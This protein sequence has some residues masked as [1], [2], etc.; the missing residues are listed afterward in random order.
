MFARYNGVAFEL[1]KRMSNH[2]Q[3]N[4]GLTLS[5]STGRQGSSSARSTPLSSQI[6]TAG[7][8]GQNPNDFINSDG[9]LVGDRPV[10]LKT[11]FIYQLPWG[12]TSSFNFQSQSGKPIYSEI[13]ASPAASRGIPGTNRI[14][15]QR[16]STAKTAHQATGRRSTPASRRRSSSAA[17]RK[18]AVFGD[19]LNLFN[20]DANESVLDRRLGNVELPRAVALHPAAAADDRR[21]VPVLAGRRSGSESFRPAPTN[22]PTFRPARGLLP[23]RAAPGSDLYGEIAIALRWPRAPPRG[24]LRRAAS[25]R[26]GRWP[27]APPPACRARA[28]RGH[29]WP[30]RPRSPA[31]APVPRQ[32][33]ANCALGGQQA[34]QVVCEADI[35][36]CAGQRRFEA[37]RAPRASVP[38]R[39][40]RPAERVRH[41]RIVDAQPRSPLAAP[42]SP[43]RCGRDWRAPSRAR[44]ASACAAGRARWPG[45]SAPRPPRSRRP[46]GQSL[47]SRSKRAASSRSRLAFAVRVSRLQ[48]EHLPIARG[49]LLGPARG[50]QRRSE[51]VE[52]RR[53]SPGRARRRGSRA[54]PN[55]TTAR[56]V[57][58]RHRDRRGSIASRRRLPHDP[59]AA[60]ARRR[61]VRRRARHGNARGRHP[62]D[63]YSDRR[64]PEGRSA[65]VPTAGASSAR[66]AA[67]GRREPRPAMAPLPRRPR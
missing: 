2:W 33:L 23:I 21:E 43:R 5:K 11:Q 40:S 25:G 28:D 47:P 60:R 62:A 54:T 8:F 36:G 53:R 1:K 19:F 30:R 38:T 3:A 22:R 51:V 56:S 55:R 31:A 10:V 17:P 66:Y 4:F 65:S 44:P 58:L 39:S 27:P 9:R 14:D 26:F 59:V 32:S 50:G 61:P 45:D 29:P 52:R 41:R 64:S 35:V 16:Q 67:H 18:L 48:R 20:S 49:G 6:S 34:R 7:I 57:A 24:R 42:G 37:P 15:R 63:T 12:I 13:R 46:R